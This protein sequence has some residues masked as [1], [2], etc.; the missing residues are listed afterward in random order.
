MRKFMVKEINEDDEIR[1]HGTFPNWLSSHIITEDELCKRLAIIAFPVKMIDW[2]DEIAILTGNN[3]RGLF[4]DNVACDGADGI[5][6]VG[7]FRN[8]KFCRKVLCNV[9]EKGPHRRADGDNW[10]GKANVK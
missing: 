7:V 3:V 9:R 4:D 10:P 8:D 1:I 6:H 2:D 5:G